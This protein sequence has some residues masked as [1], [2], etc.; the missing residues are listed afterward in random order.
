MFADSDAAGSGTYMEELLISPVFDYTQVADELWLHFDQYFNTG[1]D[2]AALAEV[3]VYDGTDWVP[4]LQQSYNTG[5]AGT[6]GSPD[7]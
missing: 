5:D 2:P 3:H 7:H 1:F 4:V 6:W